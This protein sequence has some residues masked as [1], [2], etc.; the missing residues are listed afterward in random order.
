M[1][2]FKSILPVLLL[3]SLT[4]SAKVIVIDVKK[5][6]QSAKTIKTIIIV[7]YRE[8]LLFYRFLNS[9]DTLSIYCDSRRT[10]EPFRLALIEK[11]V[12]LNTDLAGKW[13]N[14]G[15]EV[16][17]V[18]NLNDRVALFA[19]KKG[20]DYR[21]WDPNSV[22]FANSVF[23]IPKE[24]PYKPLENCVD[25]GQNLGQNE[26]NSF[27]RCTDGCLVIAFDLTK[28]RFKGVDR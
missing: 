14:V 7:G 13:P 15:Q 6:L 19:I 5:T 2:L 23:L 4:L 27:W 24:R 12:M 10:S 9:K 20:N 11:K 18:I 17:I 8:S 3:T 26:D 28:S 25:W 22:P 16:L 21:F 1:R